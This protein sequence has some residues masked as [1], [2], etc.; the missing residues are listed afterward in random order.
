M[1]LRTYMI[2][3]SQADHT[4][5]KVILGGP[6]DLCPCDS[7]RMRNACRHINEAKEIERAFENPEPPVEAKEEPRKGTGALP[8]EDDSS[9]EPPPPP[10]GGRAKEETKTPRS[11]EPYG[12]GVQL[13][14]QPIIPAAV[15]AE[16]EKLVLANVEEAILHVYRK[17]AFV[18]KTYRDELKYSFAGEAA[19]IEAVRPWMVEA[20]LTLRVVSYRNVQHE[21]YITKSGANMNSV[22]LE[23]VVRF[24]HAPSRTWVDVEALGEGADSGDKAT[25]KAMTGA[26]KYA[27]R[28]T[29][30]LETGDDPDLDSS[31][32]QER[33][34]E[35][36]PRQN[37]RGERQGPPPF[38]DKPAPRAPSVPA[39]PL[40]SW[41]EDYYRIKARLGVEE[42]HLV[43]VLRKDLKNPALQVT[44]RNLFPLIDT[45]IGQTEQT[46][47][48]LLSRAADVKNQ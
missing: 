28:Q 46:V 41:A 18:Q 13:Q 20:G 10:S 36:P 11:L 48:V 45:W 33:G 31:R 29:F 26:L 47:A 15:I 6:K 30:D 14:H 21:R 5:Y 25:N 39:E 2:P 32:D 40:P 22:T 42:V 23:A 19:I 8:W 1:A 35:R 9:L 38:R 43:P 4:P 24:T 16:P 3:S 44:P 7:G 17:V 27:Q 12:P 34:Q 37:R